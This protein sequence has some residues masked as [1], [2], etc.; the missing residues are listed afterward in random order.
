[1][2]IRGLQNIV[3]ADIGAKPNQIGENPFNVTESTLT[4]I[5]SE[6]ERLTEK[7]VEN[8]GVGMFAIENPQEEL[9]R[10]FKENKLVFDPDK[11]VFTEELQRELFLF[12]LNEKLP[13]KDRIKIDN[14]SVLEDKGKLKNI[15]DVASDVIGGENTLSKDC[16]LYT[17]DAADE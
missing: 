7:G 10:M 4:D 11:V 13:E 17:S 15:M 2:N 14:L 5:T 6:Q 12:L 9:E 1:M 16:L 3:S 8:I